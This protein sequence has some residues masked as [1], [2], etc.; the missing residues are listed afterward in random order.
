MIFDTLSNTEFGHPNMQ[1]FIAVG[2]ELERKRRFHPATF[3]MTVVYHATLCGHMSFSPS[4]IDAVTYALN[5]LDK[6]RDSYH[7]GMLRK[8]E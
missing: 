1:R 4:A 8:I 3:E 5:A 7:S 6:N 2:G